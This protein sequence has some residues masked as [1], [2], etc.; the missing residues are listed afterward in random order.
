M[1][2]NENLLKNVQIADL[3][4]GKGKIKVITAKKGEISS[5]EGSKYMTLTL[6]DGNYYEEHIKRVN[7]QKIGLKCLLQMLKFDKYTINID[8][9]SFNDDESLND[10]KIK[11]HHGMLSI[12]N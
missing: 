7:G 12:A 9:S 4:Q 8:I 10:E 6:E 5:E 2:K 11:Q 1:A 3:N